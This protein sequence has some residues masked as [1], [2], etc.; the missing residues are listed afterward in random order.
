METDRTGAD[1]SLMERKKLKLKQ[2]QKAKADAYKDKTSDPLKE[3]LSSSPKPTESLS[4]DAFPAPTADDG[5]LATT[6][7]G[8]FPYI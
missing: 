4:S 1:L 7:E 3:Q 6:A 8:A 2:E 5:A